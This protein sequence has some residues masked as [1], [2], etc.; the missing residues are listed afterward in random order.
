MSEKTQV[1]SIT[2]GLASPDTI[3]S[4]SHGEVLSAETVDYR[5]QT[6][7]EDGLFCEKIF[8][9]TKDFT[10][11]CGK[12]KKAKDYGTICDICGV[13]VTT[14]AVR[15]ERMGHIELAAPCAH[16]WFLKGVPSRIAL[17]LDVAPK[18]VESVVYFNGHFLVNPG[19]NQSLQN[20]VKPDTDNAVHKYKNKI[21]Y[22]DSSLNSRQ[23]MKDALQEVYDGLEDKD[24]FD[25]GLIN[26]YITNILT[27]VQ[28]FK[29][30][31]YVHML[32]KYCGAEFGE[33]SEV[34]K[35]LLAAVD[36]E[37]EKEAIREELATIQSNNKGE[38]KEPK[39][40]KRLNVIEAFIQSGNRPEW[41]I[42]DVIPVIPPDLRALIPLEGGRNAVSDLNELYR[43]IITRNNMLKQLKEKNAPRLMITSQCRTLQEAVDA[44]IDNGKKNGKPA[45]G[46][47]G[48]PLKSLTGAL[49]GKQG[50]FRQ[51]LLGKRVDYSGRSVIAVGPTLKMFECGLP[52]EMA[53]KLLRPF[54]IH[55]LMENGDAQSV[56]AANVMID[57]GEGRVYDAL[58][59]IISYHPVLLNRAPTLHRLGI[60]AFKPVLVEGRAIR[61][62]PL[63][64][65]GFNADFDGDQMAVHVPITKE[66]QEE[67]INIMLASKNILGPKDGKPIC[68]PSQDMVLGNYYL[69]REES[70][71]DFLK[72]A[73]KAKQRGDSYDEE[74]FLAYAAAEGKVFG[75]VDEV[76]LA[77]DSGK[78]HLHNRVAIRGSAIHKNDFTDQMKNSYLL[79]TVG[80]IIFNDALPEDF[81]YINNPDPKHPSNLKGTEWSFFVPKGTNI[82]EAIARK[83]LVQPV[84]KKYIGLIINEA[85]NRYGTKGTSVVVD[86]IKDLGF[87]YSTKY[88]LTIAISDINVSAHRDEIIKEAE[89][90]IENINKKFDKGYLSNEER[91][92]AT[93][94]IWGNKDDET[95]AKT[96]IEHDVKDELFSDID[97]PLYVLSDSGA[98]GSISNFAQLMG[99]RGLM[100]NTKGA[101]IEIPVKSCFREGLS[102]SEFFTGTHGARKGGADTALK[103]ADSGYLTRRLVDVSHDVIV[104]E[105]DCG[106]NRYETIRAIV[107][108]SI[109]N[110]V[111]AS[112]EERAVGR[113]AYESIKSPITG[114]T[115]VEGNTMITDEQAAKFKDHGITEIKIRTIFGCEAKDGVCVHCYGQSLATGKL[116]EVGQAVGVMAAQSIG[117]PGTQLTMRTF[118][119]G[120]VAGGDITQG[121]PRVQ[122]LFEARPPKGE[123]KITEISG[124]VTKV[125]SK[126]SYYEITVQNDIEEQIYTTDPNQKVTVKEGDKVTYGSKL[127]VGNIKLQDLLAVT[128]P[129]FVE[130]YIIEEIHK[131]YQPNGINI[132]DKHVEIIVRQMMSKI[133]ILDG[134]DTGLLPGS[135]VNVR[136]FR[137][138]CG[139]AL[140]NGKKPA[141]GTPCIL[142]ITKTAIGS[143]SF[144]SAASFQQ[145]TT[146]LTDASIKGKRDNLHGLKENVITG[147]LIPAGRGLNTHDEEEELMDNFDV[148]DALNEIQSDYGMELLKKIEPEEPED[149]VTFNEFDETN[150][151]GAFIE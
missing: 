29:Y 125:E 60:Q 83:P 17:V 77:Y 126:G 147:R 8:G 37:A 51:N 73:E 36:L 100:A 113:F 84:K 14:R 43:S 34:V 66:A 99:M 149:D 42:L 148:I 48:R 31:D 2:V 135:T 117:E 89:D 107:D 120:G 123:A 95:T 26:G 105:V 131:V 62:H 5:K 61:L 6:P 67:A 137:K 39:L 103:T 27:N 93:I 138:L 85:F 25:A 58:D 132:S 86:N 69:T 15:R 119:T 52:R 110:K 22:I 144:L 74:R 145:T 32:K 81:P 47:S 71:E 114:E 20:L 87:Y 72:K 12:Y 4:W 79:T 118:H 53:I 92:Q 127:T 121:L 13:E 90:K 21:I 49:K 7:V 96:K 56:S 106:T 38:G 141:T 11:H 75:S 40:I 78:V 129:E 115:L 50:R 143:D 55:E 45:T 18:Q 33:G 46:N 116:V 128:D 19:T 68:I 130:N 142:G 76:K 3:R 88:G 108:D 112:L 139:E 54:L 10:C 122:E 70:K 41:M 150:S 65:P 91:Y 59:K 57:R 44:L 111:Y 98:R 151:L 109:S 136:E 134:G 23:I 80:K 140:I 104:K 101:T 24:S 1:S 9:P 30:Y 64:C 63:V 94:D 146:V 97:N 35:K 82:K 133:K 16:I 102:T 28:E 124:T